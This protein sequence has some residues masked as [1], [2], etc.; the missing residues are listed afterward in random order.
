M[1][2][3]LLSRKIPSAIGGLKR[4]RQYVPFKT[5]FLIYNSLIQSHFDYC[6]IVWNSCLNEE[7]S[8]VKTAKQWNDLLTR[9]IYN[10]EIMTYKI[11]YGE[12]TEYLHESYQKCSVLNIHQLRNSEIDVLIKYL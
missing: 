6:D 3:W 5:L 7:L 2:V 10:L 8:F 9:R 4:I 11:Y 1:C 12:S